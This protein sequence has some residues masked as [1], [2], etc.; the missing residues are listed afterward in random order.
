[1]E[2]GESLLSVINDIL[3]FSKIEAGKLALE[4][5]E[6]ELRESLGDALKSLAFRAHRKGLELACEIHPDVPERLIGDAGRLRQI[7]VNLVGNAIKFTETG[8][9]VVEVN[10][11]VRTEERGRAVLLGP[12]HGHRH[13]PD[14]SWRRFSR[15]S[16]KST[17]RPR[18]STAARD[19]AWPSARGWW[20]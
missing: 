5:S 10:C 2:S 3:D 13:S 8:E 15:P 11:H 18:A 4:S 7:L 14:E 12:R 9:V 16:S 19:W 20:R 6:F 1:M 17:R